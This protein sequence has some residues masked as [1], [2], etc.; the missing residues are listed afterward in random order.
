MWQPHLCESNLNS[1]EE[2]VTEVYFTCGI[3]CSPWWPCFSAQWKRTNVMREKEMLWHLL[4]PLF[5]TL[6]IGVS[7]IVFHWPWLNNLDKEKEVN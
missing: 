4:D 2:P 3:F 5:N 1:C 7:A 6:N